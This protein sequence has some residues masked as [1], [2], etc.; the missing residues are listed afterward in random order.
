MEQI[1]I[2]GSGHS[3]LAAAIYLANAGYQPLVVEECPS[4]FR[5]IPAA[6]APRPQDCAEFA[7]DSV[8]L[9]SGS[10]S[11]TLASLSDTHTPG[12]DMLAAMRLQARRIGV[13]F[14]TGRMP[15]PKG[16]PFRFEL[17]PGVAVSSRSIIIT[18]GKMANHMDILGERLN[19]ELLEPAFAGGDGFFLQ[20]R[21][22]MVGGS[23]AAAFED[24]LFLTRFAS[25]ARLVHR[26]MK[27]RALRLSQEEALTAPS[28]R[29]TMDMMPIEV[30][31]GELGL[32]GLKIRM[33]ANHSQPQSSPSGS[34]PLSTPRTRVILPHEA[35]L[36]PDERGIPLAPRGTTAAYPPGI[37]SCLDSRESRSA[38][39][40]QAAAAGCL[41]AIRCEQFLTLKAAAV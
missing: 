33:R 30:I 34:F 16:N 28:T 27:Q 22:M 32:H 2:L 12:S 3:G 23:G 36:V 13:R 21:Q 14:H 9:S 38:S 1:I 11:D 25:E 6:E 41:A 20:G 35:P 18:N 26:H 7:P 19:E 31:P 29:W 40:L 5:F 24:A 10:Y 39:P 17:E 37:F 8:T 15:Q 4:N